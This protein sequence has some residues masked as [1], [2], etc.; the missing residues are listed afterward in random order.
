MEE[1]AADPPP[2]ARARARE[3][4]AEILRHERLYY[5]ESQPEITDAQFDALMRELLALEEKYPSLAAPDSPARRVGGAPSEGFDT[6]PHAVP[7]LSLE[8][9]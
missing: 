7:M 5:I 9:A 3:L 6:V 8:N 1:N 4:A 2:E